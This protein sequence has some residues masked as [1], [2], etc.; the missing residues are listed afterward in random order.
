MTKEKFLQAHPDKSGIFIFGSDKY[1]RSVEV[2]LQK[3]PVYLT[4]FKLDIKSN[5]KYLGQII[6]SNLSKSAEET[7]KSREGKLKG[8]A[9][10][11]KSIIDY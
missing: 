11:V 1:K 2:E 4:N 6:Q 7:V 9:M 10:E 3:N 8:A 5:E